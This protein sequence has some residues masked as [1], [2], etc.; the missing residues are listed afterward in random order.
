MRKMNST[1][2][3][4]ASERVTWLGIL[5]NIALTVFKFVAAIIG[6][7]QA[8]LADATESFSDIVATSVVLT[9]LKISKKPQDA[10]HPYGHGKAESI[11]TAVVGIVVGIA[12]FLILTTTLR[13]ILSGVSHTPGLIALIAAIVTIF[14]KEA[15]YRYSALIA[16]KIHS[17]VIM[18]N[19]WD[20]R[21]D[22]YSSIATL[23]GI[24]GARLGFPIL[25]PLAGALVS[26]VIIKIGYD[27]LSVASR[28]LMDAMPERPT[29]QQLLGI[30]E[31]TP[32]VEHVYGIRAR[33]MGQYVYVDLKIDINPELTVSEG[34]K[35]AKEVKDKV[36]NNLE[37]V[38]DVVVHV[39]PHYD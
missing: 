38:V 34:H 13:S 29:S 6:R 14:V 16:K 8:M 11:A 4:G 25:D 9:S 30:A 15:M 10:E 35:I 1:K 20:Y 33:R 26:L 7:S 32:G 39:N 17:S 36:I 3:A 19:A 27:I 37:N 5:A 21:K 31:N 28:E 22:A 12:G 2:D 23:V 24:A 18:A